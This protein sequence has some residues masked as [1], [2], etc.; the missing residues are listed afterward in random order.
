[1]KRDKGQTNP[2]GMGGTRSTKG[3]KNPSVASILF[4]VHF[5][6]EKLFVRAREKYHLGDKPGTVETLGTW[7]MSGADGQG[8]TRLSG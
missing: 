3:R 2:M 1:M 4:A 8:R 7:A 6:Q 5:R